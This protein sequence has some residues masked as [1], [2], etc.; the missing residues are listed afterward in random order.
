MAVW[1]GHILMRLRGSF[2][3]GLNKPQKDFV[4]AAFI[5][6]LQSLIRPAATEKA[7]YRLTVRLSDNEREVM[8]GGLWTRKPRRSDVNDAMR[9]ALIAAAQAKATELGITVNQA[10]GL[11]FPGVTQATLGAVLEGAFALEIFEAAGDDSL[12]ASRKL[13]RAYLR[14]HK[15]K[16][17][18]PIPQGERDFVASVTAA[19][20]AQGI[21][22]PAN[23]WQKLYEKS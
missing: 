7:R 11:V 22:P 14:E 19:L 12:A 16:W 6:A 18:E 20:R 15:D 17:M 1:E 10:L 4:K 13:A 9:T 5:P 8:A 23:L 3:G 21:Y 2:A